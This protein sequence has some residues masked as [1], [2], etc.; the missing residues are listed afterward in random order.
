MHLL[1]DLR[2]CVYV[3]AVRVCVGFF[4]KQNQ[5]HANVSLSLSL[6]VMMLPLLLQA[7]DFCVPMICATQPLL[8]TGA[9]AFPNTVHPLGPVVVPLLFSFIGTSVVCSAIALVRANRE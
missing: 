1:D 8:A 5:S 2:V 4:H 3:V 6:I 7:I 9:A